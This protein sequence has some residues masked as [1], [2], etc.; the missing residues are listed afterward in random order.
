MTGVKLADGTTYRATKVILTT[1]TFLS[2]VIHIGSKRINAGR[3]G[4]PAAVGMLLSY[5]AN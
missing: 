3:M 1:G 5:Y 4:D 2:G